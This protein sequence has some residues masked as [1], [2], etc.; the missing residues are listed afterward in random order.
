MSWFAYAYNRVN[1]FEVANSRS[2]RHSQQAED[3]SNVIYYIT[4]RSVVLST[5]I[6]GYK[7][8]TQCLL[9]SAVGSIGLMERYK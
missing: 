9:R 6:R 8:D 2:D 4:F 1:T 3:K 7:S 5:S